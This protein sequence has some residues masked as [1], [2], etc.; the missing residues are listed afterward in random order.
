LL[1]SLFRNQQI[2]EQPV[3]YLFIAF[4]ILISLGYSWGKRRNKRIYLSAFNDLV[5]LIKPK[6]QLFTNIGGLTGYHANLVPKRNDVFR[7]VDATITLLPRQSWLYMPFSLLIQ[8]FDRLFITFYLL[9]KKKAKWHLKEVHLIEKAYSKFR[10]PKIKNED[11]LTKEEFKWDNKNFFLLYNDTKLK[12]SIVK[13][14]QRMNTPGS[15]KHI[16]VVPQEERIFIFMIPKYRKVYE[17]LKPIINWI[18]SRKF[19]IEETTNNTGEN[20][21]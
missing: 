1:D 19:I 12:E 18:N 14:A 17:N 6:D 11:K 2:T 7:R 5:S 8:R 4:T 20:G 13:L 3:F 15:V 16:A 21:A 9:P 10:G